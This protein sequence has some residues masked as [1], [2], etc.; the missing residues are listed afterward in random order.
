MT[1][2]GVITDDCKTSDNLFGQYFKSNYSDNNVNNNNTNIIYSAPK[3][4]TWH[5]KINSTLHCLHL[6]LSDVIEAINQ[7]NPKKSSGPNRIDIHFVQKCKHSLAYQLM[8]IFNKSLST[9]VFPKSGSK[10]LSHQFINV[11]VKMK[12]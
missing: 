6:H 4:Y 5:G 7:L 1:Y 9:G 12:L 3:E 2:N 8:H 11:E 10:L